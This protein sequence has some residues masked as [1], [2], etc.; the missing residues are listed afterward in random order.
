MEK[1]DWNQFSL[2]KGSLSK[3]AFLN[4]LYF[5][6][7]VATLKFGWARMSPVL[8]DLT[9]PAWTILPG[10]QNALSATALRRAKAASLRAPRKQKLLEGA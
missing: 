4:L 10:R 8:A 6:V 7:Q 3:I 1:L 2:S 5:F 9:P